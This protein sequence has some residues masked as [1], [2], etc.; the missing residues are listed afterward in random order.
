MSIILNGLAASEGI[1]FGPVHILSWGVPEVPHENV[2]EDR[3]EEEV[4][5]FHEA[6]EWARDRLE[7]I[8]ARAEELLGPV[9]ARI[10]RSADP[11]ARRCRDRRRHGGST[12]ERTT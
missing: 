4:L 6:R 12:S 8:K 2:T 1:G 9:E 3:V 7:E 5:R 11:H 10:F